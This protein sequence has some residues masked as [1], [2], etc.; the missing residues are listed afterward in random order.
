[1]Y[2]PFQIK[3]LRTIGRIP[4]SVSDV[5]M[6]RSNELHFLFFFNVKS[7]LRGVGR[8]VAAGIAEKSNKIGLFETSFSR[9]CAHGIATA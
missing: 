5:N 2:S 1:M 3:T 8:Q 9:L 4:V 6:F 7:F